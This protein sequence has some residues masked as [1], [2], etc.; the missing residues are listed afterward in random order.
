LPNPDELPGGF[1]EDSFDNIVG[2]FGLD[3]VQEI[4]EDIIEG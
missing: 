3:D 2:S 4:A 1:S